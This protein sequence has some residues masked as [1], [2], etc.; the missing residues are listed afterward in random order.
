MKNTLNL[1]IS[2]SCYYNDTRTKIIDFLVKYGLDFTVSGIT[3]QNYDITTAEQFKKVIEEN[4]QSARCLIVLAGAK[5]IYNEWLDFEVS[6]AKKYDK[7]IV[8]IQPWES[9]RTITILKENA[10]RTVRW[11]GQLI[12]EAVN[13]VV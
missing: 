5:D 7:P 11:H 2:H 10:S 6:A 12:A 4:V 3:Q 1:F 13:Q 9:S 8:V